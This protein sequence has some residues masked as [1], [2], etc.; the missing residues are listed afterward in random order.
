MVYHYT[1]SGLNNVFL[2]NGVSIH[3]AVYGKGVSIMDTDGL[4]RGNR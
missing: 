4:H 2:E 1:E 3:E